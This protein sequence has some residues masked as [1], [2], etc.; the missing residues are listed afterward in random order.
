MQTEAWWGPTEVKYVAEL[1]SSKYMEATK[2]LGFNSEK[3][4]DENNFTLKKV[5]FDDL[6]ENETYLVKVSSII[7]GKV[8]KKQIIDVHEALDVENQ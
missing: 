3:I 8:L 6:E 4:T 2:A 5:T 7:N 1:V